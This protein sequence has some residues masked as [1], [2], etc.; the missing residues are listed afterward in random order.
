M[1]CQMSSMHADD[2]TWPL[3]PADRAAQ[4]AT[5]GCQPVHSMLTFE[6]VSELNSWLHGLARPSWDSTG[7]IIV[8]FLGSNKEMKVCCHRKRRRDQFRLKKRPATTLLKRSKRVAPCCAMEL[9]HAKLLNH[10]SVMH[11]AP[12]DS[13]YARV[14]HLMQCWGDL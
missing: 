3:R 6:W 2:L 7:V 12:G 14:R 8:G 4:S 13:K 5:R 1:D 11:A 9:S 10:L